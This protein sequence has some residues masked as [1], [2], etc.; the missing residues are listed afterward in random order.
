MIKPKDIKSRKDY[1]FFH[2]ISTRW[3]DNDVR[4]HLNNAKYYE[5]FDTVIGK[6]LFGIEG[7]NLK[8]GKTIFVTA[9]TGCSYYE[10]ISFPDEVTAGLK[11]KRLGN[12]SVQYD[13]GLFKNENNTI[14]ARGHF[15]HVLINTSNGKPLTIP[16]DIK[17][18]LEK[19]L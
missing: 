6:M 14:S 4:W 1:K 15:V 18:A 13:I 7:L 5:F 19:F 11:I 12:S 17:K 10:E 2:K 8:Q 9:E 16:S 3:N